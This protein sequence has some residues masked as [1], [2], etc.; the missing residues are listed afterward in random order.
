MSRLSVVNLNLV[1][2]P[3]TACFTPSPRYYAQFNGY[4]LGMVGAVA[5]VGLI[6]LLGR[7]LL[8]RY[9]LRDMSAAERTDRLAHFDSTCLSRL[10]LLLYLV[11]PGVSVSIVKMFSCVTLNSGRSFLT[12]DPQTVC[13]DRTHWRYVAAGIA[14]LFVVPFGV[15]GFFIF[16]LHRFRVPQLAAL[17]VSNAWLR[18]A[19]SKTWESGVDQPIKGARAVAAPPAPSQCARS[20]SLSV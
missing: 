13:W 5:T 18:A 17:K 19:V 12:A 11:Y 10:L 7:Q 20:S 3:K 1:Q 14:W 9:T 4:T 16:L 6:F 8:S 2:L 15:P